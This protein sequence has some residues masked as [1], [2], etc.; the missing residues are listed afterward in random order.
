MVFLIWAWRTHSSHSSRLVGECSSMIL[1]STLANQP[2]WFSVLPSCQCTSAAICLTFV[3]SNSMWD[4]KFSPM[5][6]WAGS[7]ISSLGGPTQWVEYRFSQALS[8]GGRRSRRKPDVIDVE[9]SDTGAENA[10][11]AKVVPLGLEVVWLDA[12]SLELPMWSTS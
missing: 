6:V 12:K 9:S 5:L 4:C 8:G 2:P 7:S 11:R 10:P 1:A 3:P